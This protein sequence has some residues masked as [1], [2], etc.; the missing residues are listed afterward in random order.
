M[1]ADDVFVYLSFIGMAA[2]GCFILYLVL[3]VLEA[4]R[5]KPLPQ[6]RLLNITVVSLIAVIAS[7]LLLGV[8]LIELLQGIKESIFMIIEVESL[9]ALVVL[10]LIAAIIFVIL[11]REKRI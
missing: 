6:S 8:E 4:Y 9:L 11:R 3:K 7:S 5:D 1:P 10:G 2:I